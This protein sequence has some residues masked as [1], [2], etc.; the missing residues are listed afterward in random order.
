[1]SKRNGNVLE[2]VETLICQPARVE[3]RQKEF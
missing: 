2:I 1:M 3:V